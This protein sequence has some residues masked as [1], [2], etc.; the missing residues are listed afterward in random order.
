MASINFSQPFSVELNNGFEVKVNNLETTSKISDNYIT[1]N[2]VGYFET[3]EKNSLCEIGTIFYQMVDDINQDFSP[4]LVGVTST[5]I[6]DQDQLITLETFFERPKST[7][8]IS[9]KR[10]SVGIPSVNYSGAIFDSFPSGSVLQVVG[11]INP[12]GNFPSSGKIQLN[13]E[14]I[15]Y[16][17]K[18][19]NTLTGI[20]RGQ[21]GTTVATHTNGD[22]LR[23]I[24]V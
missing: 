8:T 4:P 7:Y 1:N 16:S 5:S 11:N 13:N 23:T 6:F 14:I 24:T 3:Y 22:Y 17:G 18:T 10:D 12:L 21:D 19:S 15:S 2:S 9:N 20:L